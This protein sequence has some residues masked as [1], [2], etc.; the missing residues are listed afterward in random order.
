[1]PLDLPATFRAL[2][3]VLSS[4]TTKK[5]PSSSRKSYYFQKQPRPKSTPRRSNQFLSDS[6]LLKIQIPNEVGDPKEDEDRWFADFQF[7]PIQRTVKAVIKH[8]L[9]HL[10]D[11]IDEVTTDPAQKARDLCDFHEETRTQERQAFLQEQR[12]R[13]L[14]MIDLEGTAKRVSNPINKIIYN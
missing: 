4:H 8:E 2:D 3:K 5:K 13:Y 9:C 6:P 10:F 1:M 7:H 14:D 12:R 11:H